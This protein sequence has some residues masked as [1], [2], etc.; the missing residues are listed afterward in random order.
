VDSSLRRK[1][2]GTGLGLHLSR[3][4]VELL[5]ARLACESEVGKGSTFTLTWSEEQ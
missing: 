1:V 5:G 2:G 3:K 4:L